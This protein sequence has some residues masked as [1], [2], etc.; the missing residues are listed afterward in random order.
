MNENLTEQAR[1][2]NRELRDALQAIFSEL[3][4]GQTQKI[5]KNPT[6]AKLVEQYKVSHK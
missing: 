3:N 1:R 6:I 5:F 4:K 2:Y